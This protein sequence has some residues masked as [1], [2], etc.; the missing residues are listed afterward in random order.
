MPGTAPRSKG[1]RIKHDKDL[2]EEIIWPSENFPKNVKQFVATKFLPEIKSW[3][4]FVLKGLLGEKSGPKDFKNWIAVEVG[5]YLDRLSQ[6]WVKSEDFIGSWYLLIQEYSLEYSKLSGQEFVFNPNIINL[7]LTSGYTEQA[8]KCSSKLVALRESCFRN[9]DIDLFVESLT[10]WFGMD[11]K[12][13]GNKKKEIEN[14]PRVVEFIFEYHK[15]ERLLTPEQIEAIKNAGEPLLVNF[16]DVNG[17][18]LP[19]TKDGD[20]KIYRLTKPEHLKAEGSM[21]DHCI[22]DANRNYG[23]DILEIL[24][25]GQPK[26]YCFSLRKNGESVYTIW[27]DTESKTIKEIR[28][29][30]NKTLTDRN[31]PECIAIINALVFLENSISEVE[32]GGKKIS[33]GINISSIKTF[34]KI[35]PDNTFVVRARVPNEAGSYYEI[36]NGSKIDKSKDEDIVFGKFS[37]NE[38]IKPNELEKLLKRKNISF[39]IENS[40]YAN[41]NFGLSIEIVINSARR[42]V[43]AKLLEKVVYNGRGV[44]ARLYDDDEMANKLFGSDFIQKLIAFADSDGSVTL[45][46]LKFFDNF[47]PTKDDK[48]LAFKKG[49]LIFFLFERLISFDSAD[50]YLKLATLDEALDDRTQEEKEKKT[51]KY[52]FKSKLEDLISN[53]QKNTGR[54]FSVDI[55]KRYIELLSS[56]ES[57][58]AKL[59]KFDSRSGLNILTYRLRNSPFVYKVLGIDIDHYDS[60]TLRRLVA[61]GSDDK[62]EFADFLGITKYQEFVQ[63]F[64]DYFAEVFKIYEDTDEDSE[65]VSEDG[66]GEYMNIIRF[67]T[68]LRRSDFDL[69]PK[70]IKDRLS[71]ILVS[72]LDTIFSDKNFKEMFSLEEISD[73]MVKCLNISDLEIYYEKLAETVDSEGERFDLDMSGWREG[74][75]SLGNAIEKLLNEGTNEQIES[76]YKNILISLNYYSL[77][78]AAELSKI[79]DR[80]RTIPSR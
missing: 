27:Y 73:F 8:Q 50:L 68:Q 71:E 34:D 6:E 41:K 25:N 62:F 46:L 54:K 15:R 2:P 11:P 39:E 42:D 13:W 17:N 10:D 16:T 66:S 70:G 59:V 47:D 74:F 78:S 40:F 14:K 18:N 30:K 3:E 67:L 57:E 38:L 28:G 76:F 77:V 22:G 9:F 51:K 55:Y 35:L 58:M 65:N 19:I 26:S 45:K 80:L 31:S 56:S 75:Y 1:E 79:V 33:T 60:K 5:I 52:I 63:K 49:E 20:L 23:K 21:L 61:L 7:L 53:V 48:N 37:L 36:V 32:V 29:F 43:A 12:E 69:W 72:N 64:V 44:Y 4:S 24:P